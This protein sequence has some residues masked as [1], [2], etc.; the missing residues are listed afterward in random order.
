MLFRNGI[1]N[2]FPDIDGDIAS[3]TVLSN[4]FL[5]IG[6]EKLTSG[7]KAFINLTRDLLLKQ[8]PSLFSPAFLYSEILETIEPDASLITVISQMYRKGCHFALDDFVFHTKFKPFMQYA[9]IIKIDIQQTPFDEA[10]IL[11]DKLEEQSTKFLAEK[12]ETREEYSQAIEL[13]FSYFQGYFFSQPE[14]IKQKDIAPSQIHLLRI[15]GELNREDADVNRLENI[16]KSD[17]SISY[18]L[19]KYMNSAF[20]NLPNKVTSIK[21]AILFL[22]FSEVRKIVSLLAM[23]TLVEEKP[24]ELIRTS[25]MRAKLCE[26]VGKADGYHG[27]SS[28]LFLLGL[29]SLMDVILDTEM[30]LIVK[31]LPITDQLKIA[32][33]YRKGEL[34]KYLEIVCDHEKGNWDENM[35]SSKRLNNN[36]KIEDFVEVIRW[37]DVLIN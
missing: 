25:I 2:L 10:K 19:L 28:E 23:T 17:V 3:S 1:D 37:T 14:I 8:I 18:R 32:L 7:K 22:G 36:L 24:I 4:S 16:I 20:F 9:D 33:I 29:F 27:D 26:L 13:G 15:I 21:G 6:L 31:Q 5:Y 35:M 34:A 11:I 12:V 30:E